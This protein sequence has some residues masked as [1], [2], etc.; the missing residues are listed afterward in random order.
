MRT[1]FGS[2]PDPEGSLRPASPRTWLQ[3]ALLRYSVTTAPRVRANQRSA[4]TDSTS[5]GSQQPATSCLSLP[6]YP[7]QR[8]VSTLEAPVGRPQIN[9][10]ASTLLPASL[11]AQPR[12]QLQWPRG[13]GLCQRARTGGLSHNLC[14]NLWRQWHKGKRCQPL[15]KR[16]LPSRLQGARPV[17]TGKEINTANAV[18]IPYLLV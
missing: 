18:S 10:S 5:A 2:S 12:M 11:T 16:V 15:K 9:G 8:V 6:L 14:K 3:A 17:H 13:G 4:T 1:M 7:G